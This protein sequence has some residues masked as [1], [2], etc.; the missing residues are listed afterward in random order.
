VRRQQHCYA[1]GISKRVDAHAVLP[2]SKAKDEAMKKYANQ[3]LWM[4]YGPSLGLVMGLLLGYPIM[5]MIFG[6]AIA[7]I[8]DSIRLRMNKRP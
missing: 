2:Q 5:G 4:I 3:P 8:I 7:I 6:T 1:Q